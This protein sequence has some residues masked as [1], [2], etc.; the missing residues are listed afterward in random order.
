MNNTGLFLFA[1]SAAICFGQASISGKVMTAAGNGAAIPKAP[2]QAKNLDTNETYKAISAS[3]GSYNLTL[4]AGGYEI[5]V[6]NV[7]FFLP[8]HQSGVQVAAGQTTRLDIRLDDFQLNTLG[9]GG[10]QFA[11]VLADKPTPSGPAPRASDGKPD[12]GGVWGGVFRKALGDGPEPLPWAEAASKQR[13]KRGRVTDLG[14]AACLPA[15]INNFGPPG[16]IVQ[17]PVEIVI[18]DGGF[19][20]PREIYLDGREHPKNFYPSWMGHSVGHWEGDT[21]V[22]DTIGF[23]DLGWLEA[24]LAGLAFP[25]TEKLRITER[26]RRLDRGHLEVETTYDDPSAFKKPFTSQVIHYLLPKEEEVP[27]YVCA[28]NNRDLPHLLGNSPEEKR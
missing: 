14:T 4:P 17:T 2:V 3:D 12:L 6:G 28:E 7:A 24:G 8:F 27:E 9:D 1:A 11:Q 25:Q 22:V 19:N 18:I 15:G 16:R 21:L 23:N 20:P 5:S 10:E 26:Y 13:G